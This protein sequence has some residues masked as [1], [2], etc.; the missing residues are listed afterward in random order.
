MFAGS[1]LE[2]LWVGFSLL[3]VAVL[4]L[5]ASFHPLLTGAQ[6]TDDIK[7]Q[8]EESNQRIA[9]LE[10]EIAKYQKE[11]QALGTQR[12][13]LQSAI[14]SLDISRSKITAQI[15]LTRSRIEAAN[16]K[17]QDLGGMIGSKEEAIALDREAIATSIRALDRA[18]ETSLI[19]SLFS[20][21][22]LTE[23]W[24]EVDARK[25]LSEA[26]HE[27]T[28]DLASDK[29]VLVD[30]Q[31][32]VRS[33]R[34]ELIA[35]NDQLVA[36][37]AELK[38]NVRAKEQLLAETKAQEGSY[39][40]LINQKRAEQ[41]AFQATLY[42]LSTK[43]Q[44]ADTTKVPSAGPGVLRWPLDTVTITQYFGRTSDSGR[45]YASGTHD[46]IDL[47]APIG[48][49]VKAALSGTVYEIN[50]GAVQNC[51]YGKWVLIK[52]A[53][54]LATLY[55]HLSSVQVSK[56]STVSSGQVIGYSGMTGYSTGP[57]LHFTVY[58]ADSVSLKQY[59]CKSGYTVT[60]PVA[61]PNGYLNP[62]SY[63]P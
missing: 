41:A 22:T 36:Q 16:L 48:T 12:Q 52:H 5:G 60:I 26:L 53:N 29:V 55:A 3:I 49:P 13:T 58:N 54:G 6:S 45:L 8:I 15:K 25:R 20:V 35:L 7:S 24:V 46:G 56:G 43:L 62:M 50:L 59:T 18:D 61:P 63:L 31:T 37:E 42:D 28:L 4:L 51:Q 9:D 17:I 2:K 33:T 11:L 57:H 47:A 34:E 19:E 32:A 39:Q 27:R 23:A 21:D 40:A 1:F 30:Q 14:K 10:K 38:A 44:A